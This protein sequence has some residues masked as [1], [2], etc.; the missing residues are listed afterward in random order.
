[1]TL[2]SKP[3][4]ATTEHGAGPVKLFAALGPGDIVNA[5]RA[6]NTGQAIESE[7]SIIFSG[8]LLEYC[9]MRSIET[10][11]LSQHPRVD[12]LQDGLLFLEN[13]P[14]WFEGD[15]GIRYHIS[16]VA[17]GIYLAMRA[18]RFGADLAIIDSGSAHYF[19]LALFSLLRITVVVNFHNSLWPNGFEPSRPLA[20]LIR[21][22]DAWFFCR[23]AA[24]AIGV[25]PECERQARQLAGR[26]IPFFEYRA[27]FRREGFQF[28]RENADFDPFRIIFVGRAERDKGVLDI[29]DMATRLRTLAVTSV[30]FE[31]CGD[32]RALPRLREVVEERQLGEVITIRGRLHRPELLQAYARAHALLVPTRSDF[33]EG[34]PQVCAEAMLSG[35]PIITSRLSNAIPVLA[36]AV[37]EAIPE[38]IESYV[39]QILNLSGDQATYN[40]LRDACPQLSRQF[41]DRS[42]SYP[43]AVDRL[44]AHLFPTWKLL[45]DYEPLFARIG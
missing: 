5:H 3:T 18:R 17:Y 25:S 31:V 13:R 8:Q 30:A 22:L 15:S 23:I 21:F 39:A 2:L 32:G 7:T 35:I 11:G 29:A 4:L 6:Q 20:K 42:Q 37:A 28:R 41:L 38:D 12:Q 33:C 43:A 14:R 16:R 36:P 19:S 10:L 24:A 27:Q 45:A 44:I 26:A 34:L 1:M 9:R 40:R